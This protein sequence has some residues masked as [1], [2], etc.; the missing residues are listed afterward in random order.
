[1]KRI[2]ICCFTAEKQQAFSHSSATVTNEETN[3]AQR[4]KY[5]FTY[6]L[7]GQ[8]TNTNCLQ[9][10]IITLFIF[11]F[12]A[13]CFRSTSAKTSPSGKKRLECPNQTS[14][15]HQLTVLYAYLHI[16]CPACAHQ[17]HQ[18]SLT[19]TAPWPALRHPRRGGRRRSAPVRAGTPPSGARTS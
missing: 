4:S 18:E 6:M 9:P 3:T 12:P 2:F 19:R 17:Q 16:Q 13:F 5:R 7:L 14:L 10:I 1:V 8:V 15:L 11:L